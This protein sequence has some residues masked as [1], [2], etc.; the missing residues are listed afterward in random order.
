MFVAAAYGLL[1]S[2][3]DVE[4]AHRRLA[5]A[6]LPKA[7]EGFRI[8]QLSD[9]HISPFMSADEI[10]RC[11]TMANQLKTDLVVLTGDYLCVAAG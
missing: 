6:R 8:A 7:F 4:V 2:R 10:R 5:L 11:V 1:Y 9:F 3:L